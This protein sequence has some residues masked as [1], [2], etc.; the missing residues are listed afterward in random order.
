M[1][2]VLTGA[3][4][5]IGRHILQVLEQT[6][7]EV[8]PVSRQHGFDFMQM[9]TPENWLPHLHDV[10]VVINSVGIITETHGQT[11]A[12]LHYHAPAALFRACVMAGVPRVVQISALGADEQAFTPYQLSKKAAD[13]VLRSLP[14]EWFVL[15]PSLVYGE[16]GKSSAMFRFMASLPVIP[17]V[18]D[19]RQRIQPVHVSDVVATVMQCLQAASARRTLDVVGPYPLSFVEWLQTMRLESGRKAAPTLPI[20]FSLI[21]AMAHLGRFIVPM[22][23][24]DNLRMLQ[25]GN[26]ATVQPLVDFLGRMPLSVEEAP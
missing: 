4:G 17:L 15:R 10:E 14:L 9:L 7:H 24:P 3:S 26:T 21:M 20:P 5:F 12:A 22:L 25:R 11:F 23:H 1:K 2:I 18:G 19:G 16:G 6:G 8:V 13:D